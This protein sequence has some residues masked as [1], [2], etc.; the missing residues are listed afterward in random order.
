MKTEKVPMFAPFESIEKGFDR[1]F[2]KIKNIKNASDRTE[3]LV[4]YGCLAQTINEQMNTGD[5]HAK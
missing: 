1:L 5:D 3:L 2:D 4:I